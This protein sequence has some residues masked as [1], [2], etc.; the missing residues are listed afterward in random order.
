[1]AACT[2]EERVNWLELVDER[3]KVEYTATLRSISRTVALLTLTS[4]IGHSFIW[5]DALVELLAVEVVLQQLLD[6]WDTSGTTNQD[7][8]MDLTLVHLGVTERL[9][10][11]VKGA[12]EEV[13][14]ELL[15]ASPGDGGVEVNSLIQGVDLDAGLGA[16]G[17]GAL[18]PLASGAQTADSPLVVADVLLVLALELCDEVVHHAVVE[19]FPTKMSVTSGGLDLKD[20]IFNGQDGHVEGTATE[21]EDEDVPLGSNL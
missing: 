13:S 11:W 1:M 9:L 8:V 20:T 19:I 16:G 18:C 4:A 14:V 17:Q 21:I 12:T 7:N 10:H 2:A 15:K 6:L 5:V 3:N